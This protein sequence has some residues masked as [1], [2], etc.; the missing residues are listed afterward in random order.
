MGKCCATCHNGYNTLALLDGVANTQIRLERVIKYCSDELAH[1]DDGSS[2]G[3]RDPLS[4][5][6]LIVL[7]SASRLKLDPFFFFNPSKV[8]GSELAAFT[9]SFPFR[10]FTPITLLL[11]PELKPHK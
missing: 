4:S 11:K 2:S 1:D 8:R 3:E 9:A 5:Y 10:H 6:I 7:L